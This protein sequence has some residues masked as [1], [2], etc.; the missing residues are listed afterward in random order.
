MAL[1]EFMSGRVTTAVAYSALNLL[2]CVGVKPDLSFCIG[3]RI[4]RGIRRPKRRRGAM[5][6]IRKKLHAEQLCNLYSVVI[7]T[8]L[9][10]RTFFGS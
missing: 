6:G 2:P 10:K 8:T 3:N 7:R 1:L 4:L 5:R 9:L